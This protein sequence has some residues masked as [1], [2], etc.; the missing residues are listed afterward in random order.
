MANI[1]QGKVECYICHKTLTMSC[2]FHTNKAAG[3]FVFYFIII[4]VNKI[5]FIVIYFMIQAF[6]DSL[7]TYSNEVATGE[8]VDDS[9]FNIIM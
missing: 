1:T 3:L 4:S 8:L 2:M 9:N 5:C 6:T 7:V